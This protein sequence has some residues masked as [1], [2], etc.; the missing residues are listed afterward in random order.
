MLYDRPSKEFKTIS[1]AEKHA[2]LM[3]LSKEYDM[4][5]GPN[6]S[7]SIFT[8]CIEN[9]I[10]QLSTKRP[11]FIVSSTSWTEDEDFSILLNALQ[12]FVALY[13]HGVYVFDD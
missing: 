13:Y 11:G 3:K 9:G 12:G 5:K 8:E 4:F 7:S 1:L 10:V 2:F 6:E